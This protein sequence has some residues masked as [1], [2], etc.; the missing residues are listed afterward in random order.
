MK[1]YTK[2]LQEWEKNYLEIVSPEKKV[3]FLLFKIFKFKNFKKN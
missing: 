1:N 3:I 2:N